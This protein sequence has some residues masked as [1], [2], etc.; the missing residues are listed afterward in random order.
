MVN[1]RVMIWGSLAASGPKQL[2]IMEVRMTSQVHQGIRQDNVSV[3]VQQLIQQNIDLKHKVNL[4]QCGLSP[5]EMISRCTCCTG[6]IHG[7][8]KCLFEVT[9]VFVLIKNVST[10]THT[11]LQAVTERY[12]VA[13]TD[14]R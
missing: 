7:Y 10:H 4:L 14:K 12:P 1:V 2:A 8:W 9:A 3:A 11:T 5:I 6:V 13:T